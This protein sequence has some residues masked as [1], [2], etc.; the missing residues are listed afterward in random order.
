MW[1]LRVQSIDGWRQYESSHTTPHHRI[2]SSHS[3]AKMVLSTCLFKICY[4]IRVVVHPAFRSISRGMSGFYHKI[5]LWKLSR[6][7][8][9]S[10]HMIEFRKVSRRFG[11][12]LEQW[13]SSSEVDWDGSKTESENGDDKS[14]VEF[15]QESLLVSLQHFAVLRCHWFF[16]FPSIIWRNK[17]KVSVAL[18]FEG[19]QDMKVMCFRW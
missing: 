13:V 18:P 7:R 19:M 6:V 4:L 2:Y 14:D 9:G 12:N 17:Q 5:S 1:S 3:H 8:D 10:W 15:V 11:G 16:N